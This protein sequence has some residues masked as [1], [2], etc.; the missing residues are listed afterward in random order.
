MNTIDIE[1]IKFIKPILVIG[2]RQIGKTTSIINYLKK[3]K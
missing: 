2:A 1:L 3:K